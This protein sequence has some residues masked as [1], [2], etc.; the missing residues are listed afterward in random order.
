MGKA[1]RRHEPFGRTEDA[2][3]L[4]S[5]RAGDRRAGRHPDRAIL[6]RIRAEF[7]EMRGFSPTPGQAARLFGLS[8]EECER[9]LESLAREGFL[10]R[11]HDGRYRAR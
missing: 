8:R 5:A 9:V 11:D 4:A 6:D 2:L 10:L 1:L 3:S 7:S